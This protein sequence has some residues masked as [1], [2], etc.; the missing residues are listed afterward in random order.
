MRRTLS[1]KVVSLGTASFLSFVAVVQAQS[2]W[3]REW[4]RTLSAGQKEGQITVYGPPGNQYRDAIGAFADAHPKIRLNYVPGSGTNNAQRLFAERRAGKH[5]AD[6]FVGG[7]G[8]LVIVL[9]KGGVLDP[10]PPVLILPENKD[11]SAWF[12][13]KHLYAD[14]EGQYVFMMQGNAQSSIGACNT[15]LVNPEE[16]KSYWDVLN[17]KWKGKI[18]AYD[19]KERG[20]IQTMR[21]V[22]YNPNVGGEFIRRLFSE[23]DVAISRDQR[24]MLDWVASGK[25]YLY[26]FATANDVEEAQ[27]K[28]L[29]VGVVYA[30]PEEGYISGGFGHLGLV[31]KAPHPNAAKVFINWLLSKEGQMQW[32][33][34][35]DNNSFRLDIP[36]GVLTDQSS[37]PKEGKKYLISSLPQYE[38][39][40][41]L[42][43][44]VDE[45]L[46]KAGKK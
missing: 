26:L 40:T 39:V 45:A 19:P 20:H 33:K 46:A 38:D 27:K 21:G 23:M 42:L 18:V 2:D 34:K 31:N 28:G 10:L 15:K 9:F 36:K 37:V 29:P 17:P 7:S 8:T 41:P 5:L 44:I 1:L 6:V 32:Q 22:Y 43:K 30:P 11:P 14:T 12:S 16:I 3:K 24:V 25:Y 35:T 13:K 4:E